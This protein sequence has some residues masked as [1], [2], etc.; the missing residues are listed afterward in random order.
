MANKM[1]VTALMAASGHGKFSTVQLL[2]KAGADKKM[3]TR[4]GHCWEAID[5]ARKAGHDQIVNLLL[6]RP[7]IKESFITLLPLAAKWKTI[8]YLLE[9]DCT[10]L[11]VINCS[12]NEEALRLMLL[13]WLSIDDP[14]PSWELLAEAVEPL[15]E[16]IA[17]KIASF[18]N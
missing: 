2:L 9:L 5:I 14:K 11:S 15:D 1:G 8:G 17:E 13:I 6:G 16:K 3:K 7:T 18:G 4:D 10:L 12:T